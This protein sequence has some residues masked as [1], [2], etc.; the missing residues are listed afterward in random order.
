M[1]DDGF[2]SGT[3]GRHAAPSGSGATIDRTRPGRPWSL[4]SVD[5]VLPPVAA[6]VAVVGAWAAA[7]TLLSIPPYLLPG[8]DAVAARLA[9][10]PALYAGH[11]L[12][13]LERIVLGGSIGVALGF[14]VAVAVVSWR[15]LRYALLPYVVTIRVLPKVAIAPALVIYFG[16]GRA[17]A[18]GFVALIA[19]FPLALSTIAGLER[20]NRRYDDL[21]RSVD[22]N[23]L[24]TFVSV[25]LRFAL[26]EIVSGLKQS[27][28]LAV[29]GAV[30][31]EWILVDDGLGA[32]VLV[33]SENLV[34]DVLLAALVV[35]LGIGLACYG[36]V[37]ALERR[38]LWYERPA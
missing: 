15:P 9:G 23:P 10:N 12:A 32:L 21:L 1:T 35:L 14:A 30:V 16:T 33:A 6:L 17:T 3:E 36:L 27:V 24:R 34:T 8:P 37:A 22:A 13:T 25:R 38:L 28:T 31:A 18:A 11:A 19:F 20:R 2:E 5:V 4:P 26:P 7:T 29:V